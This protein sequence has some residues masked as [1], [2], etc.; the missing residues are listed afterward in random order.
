M[1]INEKGP[2]AISVV[3]PV[4]NV[5]KYL[6][7]CVDSII[8]QDFEDYEIVLVDDGSPD[9]CGSIC[10]QY[11]SD[12]KNVVVVH[13]PNGGLSDARNAGVQNA[14]GEYIVFVDS[15]DYVDRDY[16]STLWHL[17]EQH[18]A[19]ITFSAAIKE[20]EGQTKRAEPDGIKTESLSRTEAQAMILNGEVIGTSACGKLIKR[21]I[22][23]KHPFPKGKLMEDL[24]TVYYMLEEVD[25]VSIT[26]KGT[27]HYVQHG[28]SI[29]HN[30]YGYGQ[31]DEF[32]GIAEHYIRIA[33]TK[34]VRNAA[35]T[36]LIYICGIMVKGAKEKERK[37][38]YDRVRQPIRA[39]IGYILRQKDISR[40]KKVRALIY[41]MPD[42]VICFSAKILP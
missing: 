22:C 8:E 39:D 7:K 11:A 29:L 35:Y 38:V 19:E 18:G 27:Y 12:N 23:E 34:E 2:L 42:C 1:G 14:S 25:S 13:K 9:A 36:R 37:R 26:T 40:A 28:N 30:K 33:P 6:R 31:S 16:L 15:D 4:Y 32:I 41:S 5:E 17:H 3:V 20:T 21:E 24:L 10:D